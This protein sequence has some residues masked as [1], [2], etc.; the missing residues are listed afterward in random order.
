MAFAVRYRAEWTDLQGVDWRYDVEEDGFTG[1]ITPLIP[2]DIP[3]TIE[4]LSYSDDLLSDPIKGSTTTLNIECRTN[5]QYIGLYSEADMTF[6]AKVYRGTTPALHWQGWISS[7]YTEPYDALPY[8][9]S[10][11]ALDGLGLLKFIDFKDSV[12]DVYTGRETEREIILN[13]LG[14][15]G[16]TEFDEFVNLYEDRINSDTDDSPLTQIK[17]EQDVFQSEDCYTALVEIL[18]HYNAIIRQIEGQPTIYRPKELIGNTVYGRTITASTVT[19]TTLSPDQYLYRSGHNTSSLRDVDGGVMMMK[20]PAARIRALQN[21]NQADSWIKNSDLDIN[22]YDQGTGNF[23]KWTIVSP[24]SQF[25][26]ISS[27][28]GWENETNGVGIGYAGAGTPYTSDY[29]YQEFAVYSAATTNILEFAFDYRLR[30]GSTSSITTKIYIRI[31]DVAS[32]IY[33]IKKVNSETELDESASAANISTEDIVATP[34]L[35][36]WNTWRRVKVGVTRPGPYEVRI[37]C[38]TNLNL[39]LGIRNVVFRATSDVVTG[40]YYAVTGRFLWWKYTGGTKQYETEDVEEIVAREYIKENG[41]N[42]EKTEISYE[43]GDVSDTEIDNVM[44]QFNGALSIEATPTPSGVASNFASDHSAAYTPGGVGVTS[45]SNKIVFTSSVPGQNFTGATSISNVS[46]SLN[47]TVTTVQANVVGQNETKRITL[48]GTNGSVNINID[49]QI[50]PLDFTISLDDTAEQFYLDYE[51]DLGLDGY[52]ATHPVGN[53]Y[54]DIE[55]TEVSALSVSVSNVSGTLQGSVSTIQAYVA[56]VARIDEVTLTGSSGTAN[57]TCDNVTR[58][59]SMVAITS[60]TESWSTRGGSEESN[61]LE[62]LVDEIAELKSKGRQFLQLNIV[63][64]DPAAYFSM[65]GNL[66]D[67][68]NVVGEN[69]R[70]FIPNRATYDTINRQWSVDLIEIGEKAPPA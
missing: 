47:G 29:M 34:G 61:L 22:S 59:A 39:T 3:L 66:Q 16:Y 24:S 64:N 42:G 32:N 14:K 13:I 49:G 9:V 52:I 1:D 12:G 50:Y 2:V 44:D 17:A 62:L 55:K 11:T 57:V 26:K 31:K 68:I 46:G 48:S 38:T 69:N 10:I 45:N 53:P 21:Y 23:D 54:I 18:K 56:P 7:D 8:T 25:T 6:R 43:L 27:I 70:V 65:L 36:Q 5:F 40:H 63:E 30:N 51:T 37:Y 20:A 19:A 28:N 35:G 4:H 41:V 15:I 33:L 58:L 67:P 60:F